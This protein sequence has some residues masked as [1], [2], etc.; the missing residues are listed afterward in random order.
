VSVRGAWQ[1]WIQHCQWSLLLEGVEIANCERDCADMALA[2][3]VL[4]GQVLT[5]V[6][7]DEAGTGCEFAFDL[8]CTLNTWPQVPGTYDGPVEQWDLFTPDGRVLVFRD[9]STYS[10]QPGDT[11]PA[12]VDYRPLA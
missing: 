2:M 11:E 10:F 12:E 3:S 8:G 4:S 1:L 5:A 9:D 6:N 7:I